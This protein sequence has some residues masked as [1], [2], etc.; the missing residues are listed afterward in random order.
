MTA[1]IVITCDGTWPGFPCRGALPTRETD[2][3]LARGYARLNGWTGRAFYGNDFC[4]AHS[5]PG[6]QP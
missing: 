3:D 6:G 5:K 2:V 4:P 1:R